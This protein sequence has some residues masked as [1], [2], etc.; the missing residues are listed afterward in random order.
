KDE[1]VY[2]IL[3]YQAAN[4][5][6]V[7]K[8]IIEK[9]ETEQKPNSENTPTRPDNQQR[10]RNIKNKPQRNRQVKPAESQPKEIKAEVQVVLD[11]PEVEEKSPIVKNAE[12]A[13]KNQKPNNPHQ[14]NNRNN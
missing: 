5:K 7:A 10:N 6:A 8:E 2:Q 9:T 12:K 13:D 11:L 14:K 3:D 4:P 1:L